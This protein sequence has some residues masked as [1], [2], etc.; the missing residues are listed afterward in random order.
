[1]QNNGHPKWQKISAE[2]IEKKKAV[3]LST[4]QE[5]KC[6]AKFKYWSYVAAVRHT[7]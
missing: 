2:K 1:M 7:R 3:I 6:H 4:C 5:I